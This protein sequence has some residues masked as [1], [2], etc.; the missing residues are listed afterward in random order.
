VPVPVSTD[1]E[2]EIPADWFADT[3]MP[4][5]D[6]GDAS[7]SAGDDGGTEGRNP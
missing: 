7:G 4:A 5:P 3:A 6:D 1:G 2:W